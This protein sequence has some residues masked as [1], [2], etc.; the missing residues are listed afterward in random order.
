MK[1]IFNQF[2]FFEEFSFDENFNFLLVCF[3]F[4][5]FIDI[6]SFIAFSDVGFLA[7]NTINNIISIRNFR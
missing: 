4:E 7:I 1:I 3:D 5:A 2:L 6:S